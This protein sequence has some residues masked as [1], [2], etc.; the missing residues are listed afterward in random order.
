M[1]IYEL[2]EGFAVHYNSQ[3][4]NFKSIFLIRKLDDLVKLCYLPFTFFY[5]LIGGVEDVRLFN[6]I[7]KDDCYKNKLIHPS[8]VSQL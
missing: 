4:S 6:Y 5:I 1:L 7:L 3:L 2:M 8:E